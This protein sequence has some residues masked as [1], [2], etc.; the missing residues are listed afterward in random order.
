MCRLFNFPPDHAVP[1]TKHPMMRTLPLFVA[2]SLLVVCA[3]SQS[4]VQTAIV[5]T[6]TAYTPTPSPTPICSDK[7]WDDIAAYMKQFDKTID[8]VEQSS[9]LSAFLTSLENIRAKINNME[10]APCTESARQTIVNALF[11]K[12]QTL[13][14]FTIGMIDQDQA[15]QRIMESNS[16]IR[17]AAAELNAIGVIIDYP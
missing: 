1:H 16:S 8:D 3:P 7:G 13:T 11:D 14:D 10:I 6:Q 9:S 15:T 2:I 12:I 5:Q 17:S 4:A